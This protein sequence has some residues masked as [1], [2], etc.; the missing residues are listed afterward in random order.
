MK[1]LRRVIR[2]ILLEEQDRCRALNPKLQGAIDQMI[3][4]DLSIE[5]QQWPDRIIVRLIRPQAPIVAG[6]LRSNK[7][8]D[9]LGPCNNGFV[10]GNARVRPEY[11][12]TGVGALM[13]DVML[14]LAGDDGVTSDRVSV[15]EDAVRIW[16]Y[17][18]KSSDY[19]KKP[20][21]NEGGEYTSDP[22]D[23]CEDGSFL[24]YGGSRDDNMEDF[25]SHPLNNVYV[26][27][28][29][30]LSTYKCLSDIGRI[31]EKER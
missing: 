5:Y 4:H 1:N 2:N 29:K 13:Y 8:P 3:E 10:V 22:I 6:T 23:D 9:F 18:Y 15:S 31:K 28:D 17:F 21:D 30:S 24:E 14:E 25:Q 20:L 27:K 19:T 7:D 11:R 16:N 26:K 12:G